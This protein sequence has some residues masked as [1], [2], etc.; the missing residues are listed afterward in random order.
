[1]L[2]TTARNK[3]C[4]HKAPALA[5]GVHRRCD[6]DSC[7]MWEHVYVK[8]LI[9]IDIPVGDTHTSHLIP[10]GYMYYNTIV[11]GG[12]RILSCQRWVPGDSGDCG[13]K[14]KELECG[15]NQ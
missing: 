11:K 8:E 2:E 15:C 4:P 13:L 3:L 6:G 9:D 14:S 12:K 7:M 1:M 10:S 5:K